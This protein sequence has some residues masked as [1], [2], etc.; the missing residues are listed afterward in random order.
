MHGES[1]LFIEPA[2]GEPAIGWL[3]LPPRGEVVLES[4][5]HEIAYIETVDFIVDAAQGSLTRTPASRIPVATV[6][7]LRPAIDPFG[8]GFFHVRGDTSAFLLIDDAGFFHER[9]VLA[10]YAFD[11]T[12]WTG[13][14]PTFA[15]A[16]LPRTIARLRQ[17][18]PLILCIVGDSI[19]EGYTAS[20]F[21][22]VP[23]H[24]P[25]YGPLVAAGLEQ[26]YRS[27]VTLHNLATAGWTSDDG[28][29]AVDAAAAEQPDLV[30][31]AFGMNDAGYNDPRSYAAN[32]QA[33]VESIHH[34][35][36]GAEFVLVS[37]MLPNPEWHY[38]LIERFA[39]Y[40]D[41]LASL[42]GPG[43][44]LADLTTLWADLMTR[45]SPY[46]LTGNGIN[47]PND[48]GHRLYAGAILSLLVE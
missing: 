27:K 21:I 43:I 32:I 5:T 46:D 6:A 31:V 8:A 28:L 34:A 36:P 26:A 15:G 23:P 40:R 41:A 2:P 9:Q 24:Q 13:S 42:C 3:L 37:S 33:I 7:E 20:S 29:Y 25:P 12:H 47:H 38:P 14:T 39:G 4:A 16:R 35:A 45:K 30:I 1:L 19:S 44:V 18:E 17:R 48:F 22:G 10:S 11:R